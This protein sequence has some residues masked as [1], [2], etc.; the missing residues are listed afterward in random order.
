[1]IPHH[2]RRYSV[3]EDN[4]LNNLVMLCPNCHALIHTL[5]NCKD[6]EMQNIL[7]SSIDK[8]L[9]PKISNYVTAMVF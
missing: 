2:V 7:K 8:N 6:V 3:T 9:I 4:S 5:E 1:L